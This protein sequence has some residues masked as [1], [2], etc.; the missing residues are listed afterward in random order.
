MRRGYAA[1]GVIENYLD[2]PASDNKAAFIV[3][4]NPDRLADTAFIKDMT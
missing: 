3:W 2:D 1:V 4:R